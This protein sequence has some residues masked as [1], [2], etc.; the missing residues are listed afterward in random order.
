MSFKWRTDDP[1]LDKDG[2]IKTGGMW[3][4][5]REWWQS[6]KFIKALVAGYG[7]GKT[8]I[9]GKRAIS[10]ALHN[11]GS[12]HLYVSPSY[13]IAKRTIIPTLKA[14]LDGRN[15]RYKHNKTDN[16]FRIRYKNDW[17][18]IWIGSG[19]DPDSLKGPNVGSANIDEPFIQAKDVLDQVLARVRDPKARHREITLTGTPEELNWGYD[20]CA[21]DEFD[22]Y[23]LELIQAATTENKALP[24]E[25][26]ETL[27]RAYDERTAA[28]YIKGQFINLNAGAVYYNYDAELNSTEKELVESQ[29]ILVG[30]DFNVDPMSAT[31]SNDYGGNLYTGDEIVL[32]NSNTESLCNA[33]KE[34]YPMGRFIVYPDSTGKSRSSKGTTDFKIIS[35]ILDRQLIKMEY[36]RRN[37]FVR[38][39][40]NACNAMLCGIDGT[41]KAFINK[42]KCPE[43]VK[44]L[45]QV[46]FPYDEYKRKNAKRTHVSDSWGYKIDRAY[47][48][49]K[50][51]QIKVT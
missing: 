18:L 45:Q 13:K 28:A 37:P 49:G 5:Q 44:D 40:F 39:R 19:D 16:E 31:L 41:R 1:V 25:F 3:K 30:M 14:L 21:G 24:P 17:G 47:P 6:D 50:R 4:P 32:Q 42:K 35:D 11:G 20:I 48:F 8:F 43:L 22:N 10:V 33:I 36:P 7:G 51:P 26:V 12:P 46:S 15:I 38:D 34:K 2:G 9:S 29:P 27:F 23:D